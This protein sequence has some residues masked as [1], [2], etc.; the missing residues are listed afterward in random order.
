MYID[1]AKG[2][3][4]YL[5]LKPSFSEQDKIV[6]ESVQNSIRISKNIE[7]RYQATFSL[8]MNRTL[9]QTWDLKDY[10]LPASFLAV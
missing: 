10:L 4:Y 6:K 9:S 2:T 7:V 8:K 3:F 1:A 5:D